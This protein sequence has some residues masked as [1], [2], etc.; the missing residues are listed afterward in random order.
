MVVGNEGRLNNNRPIPVVARPGNG[1]IQINM[2][3]EVPEDEERSAV[4]VGR[5]RQNSSLN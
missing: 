3:D 4:A 5:F 2:I 1:N